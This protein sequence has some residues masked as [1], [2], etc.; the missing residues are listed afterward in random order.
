MG[1]STL[2]IS[3]RTALISTFLVAVI[4]ISL[5]HKLLYKKGI[6]KN[7]LESLILLPLFMPPSLVG[8]IILISV[9]KR[10]FVGKLLEKLFDFS[11]IFSWQGGVLACSVVSLP[12]MYQ[13]AKGTLSSLNKVYKEAARL[14]GANELQIFFKITLP[15][16]IHGI[17]SGVVLTFGRAFGE[18]GATMMVTGNIPGK[19]Q[20]IPMQ[21]Y[22]AVE[23]GEYAK[24]NNIAFMIIIIS[25]TLIFLHNMF[26]KHKDM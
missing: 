6:L 3:L 16:C 25:T 5:A 24:A 8:Y 4:G 18:F 13:A 1:E 21:L 11:F 15:I 26:L 22:Y 10:S 14:D 9:G 20:N 23:S 7:I 12:I 19:T 17:L 2:F